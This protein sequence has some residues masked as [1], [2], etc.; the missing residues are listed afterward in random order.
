[1]NTTECKSLLISDFT[2]DILAGYLNNDPESP[3]VNA[4]SAPYGQVFQVLADGNN[5]CWQEKPDVTLI[6]TRPESVIESFKHLI[7]YQPVSIDKI[8]GDVDAYCEA[9]LKLRDRVK[10]ALV[11][12]WVL[13][14][15]HRGYGLL[16]M[17][18]GVGLTNA[19]MKMNIRLSENLEG[20]PNIYVLN[21]QRWID[22]GGK[23]AFNP[24]LWYMAKIAFGKEVFKEA[25]KDVKAA[26]RG[27]SGFSR[28]LIILDLDDT[29]WGGTVGEDGWRNLRL[30]GHDPVGEA[31][32]D[33]Q[34]GLKSLINR[35]VLLGIVSKNDETS[36]LEAIE[37]HD[38]M[39]LRLDDFAGWKINWGDKARNIVDLVSELNLGLQSV[40]FIDNDPVERAR[41]RDALP[42]VLV[43]EWPEKKSLYKS[44]LLS[45]PYFDNPSISEEDRERT[46]MYVSERERQNLR[47]DVG[48]LEDWLK[49]LGT[50]VELEELNGLNLSRVVQLLNKTNQFNLSTRRLTEGELQEWVAAPNRKFWIVRVTDRFGDSGLT[51]LVSIEISGSKASIID[52]VLSCRVM[53]RKIEEILVY[54]VVSYAQSLN[55]EEVCAQYIPTPKNRP[56]LDFWTRSGFVLDKE[57]QIFAWNLTESFP[58]PTSVELQ[59]GI[60]LL[61]SQSV[62]RSA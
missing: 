16:D 25:S 3:K 44:T 55:L 61:D 42:E 56:T 11:P 22:S 20:A 30:G 57:S 33:F 31:F 15:Y 23:Q 36:A 54:K 1:M 34:D 19:L 62:L 59:P 47:K 6:W 26:L 2:T 21:S 48:S 9:L 4:I 43:P 29:L 52:F 39:V 60:P 38:E 13:P 18:C 45:L 35:G 58:C 8:L 7:S 40:V 51:G 24:D 28:K 17:K 37:R 32:V 46:K 27:I 12:T 50:K 10:V 5:S 49:T 41:V 14:H 53:G